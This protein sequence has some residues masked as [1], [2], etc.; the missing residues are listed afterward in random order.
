M[1]AL[2]GETATIIVIL[3]ATVGLLILNKLKQNKALR[4]KLSETLEDIEDVIESATGLDVE[5][6]EVVEE[7]FEDIS[8]AA[9]SVLEDLKEDG[10]LDSSLEE[11]VEEVVEEVKESV[12]KV[13]DDVVADI[14]DDLN[15][16]LEATLGGMTV[17]ALKNMLRERNLPVSGKKAELIER[18]INE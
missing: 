14:V 8:D 9:E 7:V 1:A 3:L 17:N 12:E 18:L 11:V 4:A 6:N 13:A 15:E 5:L 10:D 16:N 2:N